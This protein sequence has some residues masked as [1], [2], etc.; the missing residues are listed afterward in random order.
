[1]GKKRKALTSGKYDGKRAAWL[2]AVRQ[3]EALTEQVE[4]AIETVQKTNKAVAD[5][6]S[7]IVLVEPV[8]PVT[9]KVA[10]KKTTTTKAKTAKKTTKE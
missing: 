6:T 5:K 9:K 4:Q 2:S 7:T 8:K 3:T 10:T 1:M